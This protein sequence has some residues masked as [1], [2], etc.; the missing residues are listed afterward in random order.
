ME[1]PVYASFRSILQKC[2]KVSNFQCV[3][4]GNS[5]E[6]KLD[7][8]LMLI[9]LLLQELLLESEKRIK[10]SS[11]IGLDTI[12]TAVIANETLLL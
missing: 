11:L 12:A 8:I 2:K 3:K 1:D 5:S 7:V 4:C 6:Q 10:T 9:W